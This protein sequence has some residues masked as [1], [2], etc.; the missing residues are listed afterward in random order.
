MLAIQGIR[1]SKSVKI[2]DIVG[3]YGQILRGESP[4][5]ALVG[6]VKLH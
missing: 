1:K 4:A 5:N 3:V 2:V 6:G